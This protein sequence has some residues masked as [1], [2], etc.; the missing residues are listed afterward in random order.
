MLGMKCIETLEQVLS[1]YPSVLVA[2]SGGVDSSVVAVVARRVHGG[3]SIAAIGISPSLP[4][5]QLAGARDIAQQFGL[6]L[7]EVPTEE[8]S[9]PRYVANAPSRCYYCKSELFAKLV[10]EAAQRRLAVV[11]DGTNADDPAG[12][13]P[14]ARAAQEWGVRSPLLE[15]GLGKGAVRAAARALGLPI[16]NAPAAPCLSSRIQYGLA[17]IPSRLQQ[18]EAGEA[19]LRRVGIEGDLRL[20]HRG[21]EARI[22]VHPTQ[23]DRIRAHRQMIGERLLALGFRRVT[24]DLGG[25]RRGSLLERQDVP[26]ELIAERH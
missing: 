7:I 1:A 13:R 22:E 19:E 17:V 25:Y 26:V 23:F 11:A 16:W 12:H 21:D 14:G 5:E 15:A 10:R 8:L 6:D 24:L 2:Y 3:R 9:D 18:V 20:R 4:A